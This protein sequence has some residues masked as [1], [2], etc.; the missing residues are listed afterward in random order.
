MSYQKIESNFVMALES[1]CLAF[2]I[3]VDPDLSLAT[4]FTLK[5]ERKTF[6]TDY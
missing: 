5:I 6:D 3:L 4:A 2:F 1:G